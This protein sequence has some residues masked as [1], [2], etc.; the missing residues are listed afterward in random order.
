MLAIDYLEFF[1]AP[2]HVAVSSGLTASAIEKFRNFGCYYRITTTP[3]T[4]SS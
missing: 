4:C 3:I 1:R 2:E